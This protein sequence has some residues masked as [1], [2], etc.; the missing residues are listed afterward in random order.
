MAKLYTDNYLHHLKDEPFVELN[1][2][3]YVVDLDGDKN[4]DPEG[5]YRDG[6]NKPWAES[7]RRGRKTIM[8]QFV[9]A[10]LARLGVCQYRGKSSLSAELKLQQEFKPA[11]WIQNGEDDT[12]HVDLGNTDLV[13]TKNAN[14]KAS[15]DEIRKWEEASLEEKRAI[16]DDVLKTLKRRREVRE[17]TRKGRE[18]KK[19]TKKSVSIVVAL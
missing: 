7:G 13:P 2:N 15:E 9:K 14:N 6:K 12:C 16:V 19:S 8:E 11:P 18:K 1:N 17:C 10:K 4:P 5:I 3:R